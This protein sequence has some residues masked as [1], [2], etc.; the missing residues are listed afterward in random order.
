MKKRQVIL[1]SLLSIVFLST[2]LFGQSK[3]GGS[4]ADFL[5]I[6]AGPKSFASGS[7]QVARAEDASAIYWNPGATAQ[8]ENSTFT[9]ASTAWLVE[10]QLTYGAGVIKLSPSRAM[11]LSFQSLNYGETEVTTITQQSGSGEYWS[12]SDLVVSLNYSQMLTDRFSLGATGKF[13]EQKIWHESASAFAVDLG[14][15]FQT[16]M[17]GLNIGMS[18]S[19]YGP[20][21]RLDGPDLFRR[22]DLDPDNLGHNE[23]MVALLKTDP[24]PLPLFFRL[25]ISQS[26]SMSSLGTIVVAVDALVPSDNVESINIGFE[27]SFM[28]VLTLRA[29]YK[30]LG[31]EDSIEGLTLGG[32][33]NIFSGA[34]GI[35]IDYS[36]QDFE[37]FGGIQ[38]YGLSILF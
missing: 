25:G 13:L 4:A 29:G 35:S 20:D 30:A 2:A 23:T 5:G 22:I 1:N 28:N 31:D 12:A 21:M 27:Y 6:G 32:G 8:L 11:G 34:N 24:W 33:I 38:T 14:L 10:T 3:I 18:I 19:N 9:F 17:E 16:Q 15:L 7:A 36:Y 26:I 37:K